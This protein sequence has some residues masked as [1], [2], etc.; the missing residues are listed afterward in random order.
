MSK[1]CHTRQ[2]CEGDL[3]KGDLAKICGQNTRRKQFSI[4]VPSEHESWHNVCAEFESEVLRSGRGAERRAGGRTLN[5]KR[6]VLCN[7]RVRVF[8]EETVRSFFLEVVGGEI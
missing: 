4:K 2:N 8:L 5:N 1:K 3:A 7:A 6:T